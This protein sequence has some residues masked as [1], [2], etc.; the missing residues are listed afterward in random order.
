MRYAEQSV[1]AR[2]KHVLNFMQTISVLLGDVK[3]EV[4]P[5]T[6]ATSLYVKSARERRWLLTWWD[7]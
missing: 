3:R 7:L 2:G 5:P 4:L 1:A 6:T